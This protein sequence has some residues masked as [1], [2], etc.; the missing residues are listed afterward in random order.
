MMATIAVMMKQLAIT[1]R[2]KP[3]FF[4][5]RFITTNHATTRLVPSITP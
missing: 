5:P 4:S 3:S 2:E 1:S